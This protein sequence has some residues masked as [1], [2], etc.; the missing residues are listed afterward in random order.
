MKIQHPVEQAK[1]LLTVEEA[2]SRCGLS[3][4]SMYTLLAK[5]PSLPVVRFGRAVRIPV[6]GLESWL[7]ARIQAWHPYD[8]NP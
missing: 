5:D 2:A 1:L 6:A 7:A 8:T 3:R 4:A